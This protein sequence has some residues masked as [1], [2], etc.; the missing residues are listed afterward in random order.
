MK[1]TG[2]SGTLGWRDP[3]HLRRV[4]SVPL[5]FDFLHSGWVKSGHGL[6]SRLRETSDIRFSDEL[7]FFSLA[8]L[9]CLGVL[10]CVGLCL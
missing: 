3:G 6:T 10:C 2:S 1:L 7:L 9:L 4:G 5:S 8:T